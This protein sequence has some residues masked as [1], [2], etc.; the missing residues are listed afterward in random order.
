MAIL[1]IKFPCRHSFLFKAIPSTTHLSPGG[2][3]GTL[4][5][6]ATSSLKTK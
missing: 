3:E 6:K 1:K 4:S 5:G 2:R